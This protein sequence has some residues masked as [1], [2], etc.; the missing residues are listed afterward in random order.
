MGLVQALPG[1][2]R[3]RCDRPVGPLQLPTQPGLD[4]LLQPRI[5]CEL[6]R[7]GAPSGGLRLPLR[8]RRPVLDSAASGRGVA[9]QLARDRAGIALELTSD[10]PDPD[11]LRLQQSEVLTLVERQIAAGG[12][13]QAQ[14]RHAASVAKPSRR[15]WRG[16]ADLERGVLRA[17][18]LR[19]PTPEPALHMPGGHRP[20]RGPHRGPQSPIRLLLT[21]HHRTPP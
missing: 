8:D 15:D 3:P 14:R 21:S 10:R 7:L 2:R 16:H 9:S 13:G 19:D 4:V 1:P 6:R 12:L 18:S 17:P 20:T 11:T 5:A